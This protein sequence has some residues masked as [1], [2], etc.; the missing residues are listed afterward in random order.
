MQFVEM[1]GPSLPVMAQIL[2]RSADGIY[3]TYL[4]LLSKLPR[5]DILILLLKTAK[6]ISTCFG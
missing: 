2:P 3:R 5:T 1:R 6:L 4:T